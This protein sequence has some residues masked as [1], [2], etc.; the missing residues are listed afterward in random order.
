MTPPTTLERLRVLQAVST[1][2]TIAGAARALGYTPSAVSQHLATLEREATIALVERSNRGVVLTAAGLQ[3]AGRA[4]EVLDVVRNAF[5]EI[6]RGGAAFTPVAVAAFPTAVTRLLLPLRARLAP[7][8]ELTVVAAESEA[9]LRA[10]QARQV[11]CAITDGE[12]DVFRH[13]ADL[14][15]IVL[16]TEPVR[17]LTRADRRVRSLAQ[18]ADADWVL[19][20]AESRLGHAARQA[21][22][23]AGF[24]PRV[25][26]ETEDHHITFEVIRACGAVSL[27]PDL[28][29]AD[30]PSDIAVATGVRVGLERRIDFVTRA[31]LRDNAAVARLAAL[32]TASP[33]RGR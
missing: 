16:R 11:D 17:L 8:V 12:A 27:L 31:A 13:R 23:A 33:R 22:H 19:G 7:A 18:C 32:L 6:G 20:N 4:S 15:R 29:L 2:G 5:D 3:L 24:V 25:I 1:T 30:L 14:H 9:A 10:L 28:A 21:C 26:A